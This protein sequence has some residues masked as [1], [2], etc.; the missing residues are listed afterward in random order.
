MIFQFLSRFLFLQFF[1]E[2]CAPFN[3]SVSLLVKLSRKW[4]LKGENKEM[5]VIWLREED[6]NLRPSGYEPDELPNCSTP[7]YPVD[8]CSHLLNI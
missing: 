3:A 7:R 1:K 6:L 5:L 4:I 2:N 8:V